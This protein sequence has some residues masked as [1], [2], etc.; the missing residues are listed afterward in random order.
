[1]SSKISLDAIKTA[2]ADKTV[3]T[4]GIR[5]DDLAAKI[6]V[7]EQGVEAVNVAL[8]N[9][10]CE[11]AF[12]SLLMEN[13]E[14]IFDAANALKEALGAKRARLYL[15]EN[16][17]ELQ[18]ALNDA[19]KAKGLEV[20]IGIVDVR[21]SEQDFTIHPA[22]LLDLED[23]VAGSYQAGVYV[24]KAGRL[25][26]VAADA[27]LGELFDFAGAKAVFTGF[28]YY[29]PEEAKALPASRAYNAVVEILGDRDCIVDR[30]LSRT[31]AYR[32]KS[33][34]KCVFCREGLIQLEYE[35]KE[36]TSARGKMDYFDLAEEIGEAMHTE[37]LCSVGQ[38]SAEAAR[39]AFA[40][41]PGEYEE[42]I[43]KNH[44]PAGVC[45]SFI[46]I[47]INPQTCT[48]CEECADVCPEDAIMGKR[49]YI[50]MID[51]FDCTKCGKC[52]DACDENAIIMTVDKLP[53]LPDK[54]TKVGRFRKR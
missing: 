34:G 11:E 29:T 51:E 26:R 37:T 45:S 4:Q 35:H 25:E 42:H 8:D 22:S 3:M 10:D 14:K 52:I 5:Q 46:R 38:Y 17:V 53:K 28:R 21:A 43:R 15:P 48:G 54:L 9:V 41:L 31:S 20:V 24:Q 33:C 40:V 39:S 18:E 23:L 27:R 7:A 50:H 16:A 32:R 12:Y 13:S 44:C 6:A 36:I 1:M 47:Y 30:T 2:L 19:A 49:R